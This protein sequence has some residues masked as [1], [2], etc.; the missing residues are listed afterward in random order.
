MHVF[1]ARQR[2]KWCS[3]HRSRTGHEVGPT[4]LRFQAYVL[5]LLNLSVSMMDT[6]NLGWKLASVLRRQASPEILRTCMCASAEYD[7]TSS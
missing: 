2:A 7:K 1:Y 3:R 5:R 4:S 6:F